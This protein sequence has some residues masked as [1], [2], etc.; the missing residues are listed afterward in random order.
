VAVSPSQLGPAGLQFLTDR[1]LA[2]LTL[3]RPDGSPHVTPVGV[4]WDPDARLARI[5][6][7]G[8]SRKAR[9]AAAGGPAAVCQVVEG[10][11]LTLEGTAAVS[12]DPDRVARA[13]ELYAARYRT[14]R[15]NPN[16]VAIEIAV[17][18]VMGSA[19]LLEQ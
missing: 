10:R 3:L 18:R 9:L 4:T 11:W 6:C 7:D 2:S 17:E 15:V 12:A 13:V 8:G 16:R 19:P 14:P 5:I 1:A